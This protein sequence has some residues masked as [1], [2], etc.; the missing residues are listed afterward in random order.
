[1]RLSLAILPNVYMELDE[2][3]KD[4]F[5]KTEAKEGIPPLDMDWDLY[6]KLWDRDQLIIMTAEEDKIEGFVMYHVNRH[7]HHRKVMTAI[8]DIL[9][10]RPEI[11]STGLGKLIVRTAE[12]VLKA[13]G[14]TMIVHSFRTI[15]DVKP[16][17]LG[18]GYK[19]FE[20]NYI[21]MI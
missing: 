6:I 9:A 2:L 4:Y 15:Y 3:L 11:R 12:P 19:L 10:V 16:V 5:A 13:V 18:L 8:C 7:P 20:H 17:F 1:M 14:V 21:R